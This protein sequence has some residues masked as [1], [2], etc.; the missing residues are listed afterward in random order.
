MRRTTIF[1]RE[2]LRAPFTLSLLIGVPSLFVVSADSVL[3]DFSRALGG[4]LTSEAAVGLSAGW[5]A[6]FLSGSLGYFAAASSRGSDRRLVVAGLG[7]ARMATSR[8]VATVTLATIAASA[9]FAA[10]EVRSPMV[11]PWHAA[12]AIVAFAWLYLG[13]GVVVG[14][15]VAD[16]LE[17]S[18]IVVFV[19]ILD[20]FSGPGMARAAPPWAISQEPANILIA[21]GRGES[22]LMITWLYL[23]LFVAGSLLAAFSAFVI[24][25]R[26]RS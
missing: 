11:H 19:F 1:T 3:H 6:A 9:A 14:S 18:L 7:P 2:Q 23:G 5:A 16:P 25:A 4:S 22:S 24:S 12:A 13:V 10:L 17:G 15:V 21:A 20:V 8:I 26:R